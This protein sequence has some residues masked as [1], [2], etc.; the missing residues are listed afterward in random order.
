MPPAP[1]GSRFGERDPVMP[2][3]EIAMLIDARGSA[4]PIPIVKTA[5]CVRSLQSGEVVE[6]YTTDPGALRDFEAWART[7]GHELLDS[8]S[9]GGTYR[10][11]IRRT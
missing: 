5:Q 11:V 6:V 2:V 4:C 7:T 3:Y 9:D 1:A 8:T 10:F